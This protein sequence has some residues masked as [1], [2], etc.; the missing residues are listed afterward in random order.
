MTFEWQVGAKEFD[1]VLTQFECESRDLLLDT[2]SRSTV[3]SFAIVFPV[4]IL[5]VRVQAVD[6]GI[7][8]G[9]HSLLDSLM[10]KPVTVI[11]SSALGF[12]VR[13]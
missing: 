1:A 11:E 12:V 4:L 13:C 7:T 9:N 5:S 8:G 10:N 6:K 3:L 2:Y